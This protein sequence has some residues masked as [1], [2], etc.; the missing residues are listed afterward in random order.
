MVDNAGW[1]EG[2]PTRWE[3][4]RSLSPV[5]RAGVANAVD[6]LRRQLVPADGREFDA[7]LIRLRLHSRN[8]PKA[9]GRALALVLDDYRRLLADLPAA[10]LDGAVDRY[11]ARA[12]VLAIGGGASGAG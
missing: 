10:I 8:A 11:A 4:P 6:T 5:E 7:A 1:S 9:E 2:L 12:A 3:P